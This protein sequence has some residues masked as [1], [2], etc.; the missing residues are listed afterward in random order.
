AN[1]VTL[2][3]AAYIGNDEVAVDEIT[4]VNVTDGKNGAKGDKGERGEKGAID[5]E[6]LK[7]IEQNINSKADGVLTKEQINALN[8]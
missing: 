3:V 4:L 5:E 1:T 2:T 8:E 6:K 7:E